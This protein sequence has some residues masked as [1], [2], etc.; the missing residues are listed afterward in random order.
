[1]PPRLKHH[2]RTADSIRG[3]STD[4]LA[5]NVPAPH[6]L[7]EDGGWDDVIQAV[8]AGSAVDLLRGNLRRA[9]SD[10]LPLP[11]VCKQLGDR[12]L[13]LIFP[14][15]GDAVCLG[16]VVSVVTLYDLERRSTLY[17]HAMHAGPGVNPLLRHLDGPMAAPMAQPGIDG[18][19]ATR[20]LLEHKRALWSRFCR[21][22]AALG[23]AE[24]SRR[25]RA[26]YY[27]A[28]QRLYYCSRCAG[29]R[30][31]NVFFDGPI[32]SAPWKPIVAAFDLPRTAVPPSLAGLVAQITADEAWQTEVA[33]V[34][35]G[36]WGVAPTPR[37]IS[38]TDNGYWLLSFPTNARL[39]EPGTL[40][41]LTACWHEPVREVRHAFPLVA[42][43]ECEPQLRYG[44]ALGLQGLPEEA[45]VRRFTAWRGE[46]WSRFWMDELEEGLAIASDRWRRGLWHALESL[47]GANLLQTVQWSSGLDARDAATETARATGGTIPRQSLQEIGGRCFEG[48]ALG[49]FPAELRSLEIH[50]LHVHLGR[51]CNESCHH[52]FVDAGPGRTEQMSRRTVD[53]VLDVLRRFS[54][55]TLDITGG[56][57][58]MNPH[59]RTLV[60]EASALCH[61]I[62]DR[63]NLTILLEPGFEDLGAF[64]AE[65][66]VEIAASLPGWEPDSVDRQRG[67]GTFEKSITALRQ[68]NELGYGRDDE[69]LVL[70]LVYNP[71]DW[72]M[73]S[74]QIELERRCREALRERYGLTFNRLLAMHNLPVGRFSAALE[75][76]GQH[77]AYLERLIDT[78]N[79]QTVAGLMCRHSL[80]VNWDG[81]LYDCPFNQMAQIP[82]H[83]GLPRHI[84][85]FD[86]GALAKRRIQTARHC[87]GCTS[88]QGSSCNGA[89]A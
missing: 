34:Q 31:G 78:I 72:Q 57:P 56:A 65:R 59:F 10:I 3:A 16:T 62:I 61:R 89:L 1:M 29:C 23:E 69:G 32:P 25:W 51:L 18:R 14:V 35:R 76:A 39:L 74:P 48:H 66:R 70:N 38:R 22:K 4:N 47:F 21:E 40:V 67:A 46:A 17:A 50:T 58:E 77:D 83:E 79:P 42:G 11:L 27:W 45:A 20:R 41:A 2:E 37:L 33:Y 52:C 5:A 80:S 13:R 44:A 6:R 19:R 36:G 84:R 8:L 86:P 53:L 49:G 55:K 71:P 88:G 60:N 64:L 28:L 81:T 73:S 43:P 85:N 87:F 82:L 68:L 24:A 30:W 63:C 9:G 54:I 12:F 7:I 15:S 75:K 26:G